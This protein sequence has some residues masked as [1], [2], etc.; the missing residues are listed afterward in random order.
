MIVTFPNDATTLTL[1]ELEASYGQSFGVDD[2]IVVPHDKS[3]I[4]D[5][6][7]EL[8]GMVVQGRF[9]VD[10]TADYE[11]ASE[12]VA[13][14]GGGRFEVGTEQNPHEH[15]F[16]LTLTGD[17]PDQDVNITEILMEAGVPMSG[18]MGNSR[19][20][21]LENQDAFLMVMGEGSRL[22]LHGAD[23]DKTTWTQLD[24]TV[25]AGANSFTLAE[26]TGWRAGDKI[27][28][29]STDFDLNQSEEL[30]VTSVSD[31]GRTIVFEPPLDY[32]H[33]GEIDRYD[34]P[35]GDVHILDMRAEV[36][37]LSRNVKI[38][39]D[40]NYDPSKP[41][42]EQDDQYGGHS[43]VM[44][45]G[46][47]YVSGAEFAFMGQAGI[48]GKYPVHWHE[49]G[50]VSGQYIRDS[51]IHHSF[52]KGVTIHDTN[53]A[54]VTDN[55]V[56]ETISHNYYFEDGTE[57]G[58]V[59]TDNLGMNARETGQFGNIRGANDDSPSNFYTPNGDNTWI[60]NHAAGSEDKNFYFSLGGGEG[61]NF[62]TFIDNSAHSAEGRGFYLNHGGLI[63]DGNPQGDA[64][65]PQKVDPWYVEGLTLYKSDG[66][67]V[68]G[69]EGT[70]TDS[71]FAELGSNARFRLNQTIEDSLIIG[72]S[73]NIGNPQ[74]SQEIAEG[75]SLPGGDGDFQGFQ[76]YDGPGGVSNVMFDGFE[77]GDAAIDLSNAIHK[78]SSFFV[79]GVTWGE[80]VDET[81]KFEIGGGG[82]AIG[83][84]NWARG[85]VDVDGSVTGVPGSMIYQYS[86]DGDGSRFFNAGENY[87][88]IEEWG[89]I[90]TY[91]QSSGT[92]RID[93]GGTDESN[94]GKNHGGPA[95]GL[96]VT[97]SD[98]EYGTSLRKQIPVFSEY[99]YEI[100]YRSI[101]DQFRLYLHDMDWGQSVIFNLGPIPATSSFTID[102]PYSDASWVAREVSSMA[103]LEASPD[104]AVYRDADGQVHI[105]L[106]GE[107]AHG[108]LWPQP[109]ESYNDALH[110]GVTVLVDTQANVDLD[111]LNFN[112]PG[113]DDVLPPPPYAEGQGP[114]APQPEPVDPPTVEPVAPE[115]TGET[116]MAFVEEDGFVLIEAESHPDL[117]EGW[118][119]RGDYDQTGAPDLGA[120][121]GKND[122]VMWQ[123]EDQSDAPGDAVLSYYVVIETPG[124]YDFELRD[125]PATDRPEKGGDT[126]VKIDG[127]KFYGLHGETGTSLYPE[128]AEP[129]SYPADAQPLPQADSEDGW[130]RYQ[131]TN[132]STHWGSGGHVNDT[133][134]RDDRHDIVVEF[135]QPGVYEIQLSGATPS[136]HAIGSFALVNRAVVTEFSL[137]GEESPL[138]EVSLDKAAPTDPVDPIPVNP[139]PTDPGD[140]PSFHRV[141]GDAL[142]N[143][144]RGTQGADWMDGDAGRDTLRGDAGN[145][146][147]YGG[148]G[149]DIIRGGAGDDI[150]HGQ[151]GDDIVVSGDRGDDMV[152]GGAGADVLRGGADNDILYGGVGDDRLVGDRGDDMLYGGEGDDVLIGHLGDDYLIGGDGFDRLVGG[153]GADVFKAEGA[154][155]MELI[156]D[157]QQGVD[158]IDLSFYEVGS[159]DQLKMIAANAGGVMIDL[160]DQGGETVIVRNVEL[161]DLKAEDFV[162]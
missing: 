45:G 41:L 20:M 2:I 152:Y 17:D 133:G 5:K 130:M 72:R 148:S 158:K 109:G 18:G 105:K 94:T 84:D 4:L 88:V 69:I 112:D 89:A 132:R 154:Q 150:L 51:S 64:D 29:A 146:E 134:S 30:T 56:Y 24:S 61:R 110:S 145:D 162:I 12:W 77:S 96:S 58:S 80:N 97:R 11:L 137:Q 36:T 15:D 66:V 125:Q 121:G 93:N 116:V 129:G 104:T 151:E 85:L 127:A 147:A 19:D 159:F 123:G 76:L 43:M 83:V 48:L 73:N 1:S 92:L 59:L 52:N 153:E 156:A 23:A 155:G 103:M 70:F 62:G 42:N 117:P 107:M 90:V 144:L 114:D 142:D 71:A 81:A 40:V 91:G 27:A 63:Q 136:S 161:E 149:R 39:G 124:R 126:W 122:F 68:R 106:V 67:Y 128:G 113:P 101:D 79:K 7:A 22:D 82:N 74:T 32:M 38:Q 49:S 47:M 108:Y 21:V 34:D 6:S 44:N 143:L 53:N 31:D 10:D 55:V 75:R 111:N 119:K 35:D 26:A 99:T 115:P 78:T 46:E 8:G 138:R 25:Q 33:Y 3:L 60:G 28:I 37:L 95:E 86:S 9:T 87:E 157:F 102:D 141:V 98:G 13:V 131:S 100:D 140:T 139:V 14:I 57:T 65:Q 54:E 16:T 160:Q 135:D 118:V 120:L 50:D